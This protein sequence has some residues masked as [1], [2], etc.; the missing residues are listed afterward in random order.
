MAISLELFKNYLSNRKQIVK[1]NN[2]CSGPRHI[3]YGIPQGTV[4]GP[5]LFSIYVNG[6]LNCGIGG[7]TIS[8]ADDTALIFVGD[9]WEEVVG[10]G[11]EGLYRTKSWLDENIL[12]LNF[13]KTKFM[14][15]S[16]NAI[17]KPNLTTMKFHINCDR[18]NCN[19]L[20]QIEATTEYKYLGLIL[21]EHLKWTYHINATV[22]KLRKLIY[23]IYYIR[24]ILP[25]NL[26]KMTYKSLVESVLV[27]R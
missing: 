10:K 6:L 18:I 22:K 24:D 27:Y 2:S 21:D 23:I 17:N 7:E 26:L 9:S 25:Y 1:V 4:L 20:A 15:F 3:E 8:Y 19:C 13:S 14:T 11:E 5:I 16:N 12:T